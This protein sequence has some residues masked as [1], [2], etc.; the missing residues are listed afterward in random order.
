MPTLDTQMPIWI[1]WM[2]AW[3]QWF[4]MS[5]A[6]LDPMVSDGFQLDPMVWEMG[7]SDG[8]S[9]SFTACL[10]MPGWSSRMQSLCTTWSWWIRWWCFWWKFGLWIKITNGAL[11]SWSPLSLLTLSFYLLALRPG[12][13]HNSFIWQDPRKI[14]CVWNE[15][16]TSA[17]N[18]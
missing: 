14:A 2:S 1:E 9:S 15:I 16:K 8:S 5:I 13:P 12:A 11:I 4:K 3:I 17:M 7:S 6:H 18:W 10:R